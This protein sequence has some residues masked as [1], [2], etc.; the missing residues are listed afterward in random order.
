MSFAVIIIGYCVFSIKY[1]S[2]LNPPRSK[3]DIPSTSSIRII[4][5]LFDNDFCSIAGLRTAWSF[6]LSRKSDAFNS[7]ISEPVSLAITCAIV[8]F[9]VPGGP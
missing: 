8:V 9:P 7:N 1:K 3:E 4:F 5:H 6:D 2:S